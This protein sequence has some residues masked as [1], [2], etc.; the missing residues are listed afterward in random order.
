MLQLD[1]Q[2]SSLLL[3]QPPQKYLT[4]LLFQHIC[5][6]NLLTKLNFLDSELSQTFNVNSAAI[7]GSLPNGIKIYFPFSKNKVFNIVGTWSHFALSTYILEG[8]KRIICEF[9]HLH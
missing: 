9:S 7:D 1:S 2:P 3:Q 8:K 4:Q 6:F 5:E